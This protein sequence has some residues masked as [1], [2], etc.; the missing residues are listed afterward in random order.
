MRI[1]ISGPI[2][3]G[4]STLARDVVARLS[5]GQPAGLVELDL[6][7]SMIVAARRP[8]AEVWAIV[9]RLAATLASALESEGITTVVIEGSLDRD[10]YAAD[11]DPD[12]PSGGQSLMVVLRVS[13]ASALA[14]ARRDPTRGLSRD[15]EFLAAHFEERQSVAVPVGALEIDSDQVSASE[16]VQLV[17]EAVGRIEAGGYT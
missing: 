13:E 17:I 10:G 11:L 16:A 12:V 4:K 2:A 5:E 8:E 1:L 6:L 14:R 7:R 3:S 15:P 9:R